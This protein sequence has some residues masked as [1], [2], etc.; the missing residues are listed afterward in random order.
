MQQS[1]LYSFILLLSIMFTLSCGSDDGENLNLSVTIED[2]FVNLPS[3]VS[4]FFRVEDAAGNGVAGLTEDDFSI[5]E[6]GAIIS[7][8]EAT[9]K[10]Q[11]NEQ[12][13]DYHITLMLDLSGSVLGSENLEALK[14]AAKSFID[15]VVPSDDKTNAQAIKMDIWWFDGSENIKQLQ[16]VSTSAT[17]LKA[18]IDD[19]SPAMSSDNSTNLYGAVIQGIEVATQ[20]L[21]QTR[22]LDEIASSAVVIFTDGTDQ[23]NRNTK[24]QALSSVTNADRDLSI[25]T[26]GLGGEI[27]EQVLREIGKTSFVSAANIGEL[28]DSFREIGDLING[29]ANSYYL[30]EYCSPKR[31]GNNQ[32]TIEVNKGALVGRANSLFDA[33]DFNGSCTL[34]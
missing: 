18:S 23:A 24:G 29:R 30:L 3:N 1:K 25:Y 8:F 7:E 33:S 19:I 32:L 4:V 34:E 5:Y 14:T 9:R 21:T 6:N 12:V 22:N 28:L 31:S 26:I 16:A 27:D 20:K 11:P 13:F 17:E 10:I 15:E 2:Q